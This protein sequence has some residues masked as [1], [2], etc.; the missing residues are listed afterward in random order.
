[1]RRLWL[2]ATV[3]AFGSWLLVTAV[4]VE[5]YA[6]GGS[7]GLAL[8]I[9]AAP[10]LVLGTWAGSVVDRLPRARV[11]IAADL[12]AAFGVGL[13]LL[14]GVDF[15]YAGAAVE[16]VAV[17]FLAPAIQATVPLV[18]PDLAAANRALAV[19]QSTWRVLG[20][21]IGAGLTAAGWFP[22]VVVADALSYLAAGA[23]ISGA[24]LPG[25]PGGAAPSVRAAGLRLAARSPVLLGSFLYWTANAALTA[26]LV[27]F[28]VDRLHA[29]GGAVGYLVTGLGVGYL[30]GSALTKR[31]ISRGPPVIAAAYAL[32]GVCFL[33]LVTAP[34]LP[35][36][37][38]AATMSGLPGAVALT[39]TS[40]YL[41]VAT[42]DALRGRVVAA[43]RTSDALAAVV[44]ALAGPALV[45]AAG[46]EPAMLAFAAVVPV[47]AVVLACFGR[48]RSSDRLEKN[49]AVQPI[50]N[51]R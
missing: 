38:A 44:G 11:L 1:M 26:L 8:A 17:C 15:I 42:P 43:F 12:L 18:A 20:P 51:R 19:S 28:V 2:A 6:R 13:M 14:P 41:Q 7:P 21:L 9:E 37:V 47:A 40:H 22:A 48:F 16:S 36:A 5:V 10:A 46:L 35:V 27:P 30:A 25:V 39:A 3:D 24:A 31:L 34:S 49:F 4:P 45:A 50:G 32:V 33:V 29:G 23:I